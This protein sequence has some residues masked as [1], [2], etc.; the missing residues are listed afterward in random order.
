MKA[1]GFT[2][3]ELLVVIAII[4][5]LVA[6]LIPTLQRA[7]EL[8]NQAVCGTRLKGIGT[9][10]SMYHSMH[11][12]RFPALARRDADGKPQYSSTWDNDP[13]THSGD[14]RD[15]ALD[16]F[17]QNESDCNI[18]PLY[19]L[20]IHGFCGGDQ[21]GCPSD[22]QYQTPDNDG[23]EVGFNS[24]YEI[25]YAFQPFTHHSDNKAY[26]GQTGQDG[27]VVIGGDKQ[28]GKEAWTIN[29][30]EYGGNFLSINQ[31]VAFRKDEFNLVGWNKNNVFLQDVS[32]EGTVSND[33]EDI[34]EVGDLSGSVELPDHIND[35]VL[36]WNGGD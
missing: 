8:A 18:Q 20:V 24:W 1:K 7:K 35:S 34:D 16:D 5:L 19:L 12:D 10:L 23:T 30:N 4:S 14:T 13:Q 11:G 26:P 33:P 2:L 22:S 31:S 9:A 17:W 29:H 3:I 21:F 36:I 27:A 15:Q 32:S 25:S 28:D 6:I